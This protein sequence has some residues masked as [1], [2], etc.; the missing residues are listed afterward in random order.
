MLL[1][2]SPFI[3]LLFFEAVIYCDWWEID[4]YCDEILPASILALLVIGRKKILYYFLE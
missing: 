3:F 2:F 4:I 1:Y